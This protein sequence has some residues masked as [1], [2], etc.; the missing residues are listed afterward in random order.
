MSEDKEGFGDNYLPVHPEGE[1]PGYT[2]AVRQNKRLVA[3]IVYTN[4]ERLFYSDHLDIL[5]SQLDNNDKQGIEIRELSSKHNEENC[6]SS[7]KL[8]LATQTRD[9]E[10]DNIRRQLEQS[11]KRSFQLKYQLLRLEYNIK[12][13]FFAHIM[14]R[15]SV[16]VLSSFRYFGIFWVLRKYHRE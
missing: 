10:I 1:L 11:K 14:H 16:Y 4:R 13:K 6:E 9:S 12:Q 3:E 5:R 7:D 8:N 15:F 2:K